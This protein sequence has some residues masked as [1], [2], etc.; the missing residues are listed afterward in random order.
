MA[1]FIFTQG[2]RSPS[3]WELLETI[4]RHDRAQAV[5]HEY[6]QL[7]GNRSNTQIVMVEAP[8]AAKAK[9]ELELTV[10]RAA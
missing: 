10:C 2:K 7:A 4:S 3:V 9:A 8:T 5:Y 1:Y 6:R